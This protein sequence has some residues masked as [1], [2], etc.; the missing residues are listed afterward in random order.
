MGERLQG[1]ALISESDSKRELEEL[2]GK[3]LCTPV[4]EKLSF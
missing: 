3:V 2:E 1:A 4:P